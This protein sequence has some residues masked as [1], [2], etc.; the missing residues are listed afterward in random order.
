MEIELFKTED[1]HDTTLIQS[2]K[3]SCQMLTYLLVEVN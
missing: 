2:S 3:I 1:H